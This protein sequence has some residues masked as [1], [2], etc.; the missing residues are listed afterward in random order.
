MSHLIKLMQDKPIIGVASGFGSGAVLAVQNFLTDEKALKIV[1]GVAACAGCLVAVLTVVVW[2]VKAYNAI[3][4][5][6]KPTPRNN[7]E[8]I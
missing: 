1:S 2:S 7:E 6:K 3:K 5:L 4:S 8:A